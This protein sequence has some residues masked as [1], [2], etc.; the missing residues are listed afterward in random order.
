MSDAKSVLVIGLRYHQKVLEFAT[1]PP[2]EAVG[3]YAFQTYVTAWQGDL[4][5]SKIVQKLNHMGYKAVISNDLMGVGSAIASPR[6][7]IEDI[8]SNRFAAT[9]AGLGS[10]AESGRVVSNEFG[11]RQRFIAIIT[12]ADLKANDLIKQAPE[13]CEKCDSLCVKS[14][15]TAAMSSK[16]ITFELED[17]S[18]SFNKRDINRCDWSK[19]YAIAGESGFKISGFSAG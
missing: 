1:K 16:K 19:R 6:G 4:M 18:F 8:F 17:V 2:A 9:A 7:F 3:P 11:T 13:L 12:D 10:L 14:C 5:A 15:P